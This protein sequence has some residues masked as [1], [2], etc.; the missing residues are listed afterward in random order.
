MTEDANQLDEVVVTGYVQQTR[1]EITGAVASVDMDEAVKVP[2]VNAG[3]ALAG[4]GYRV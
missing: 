1:G 3:E 2:T 4:Q